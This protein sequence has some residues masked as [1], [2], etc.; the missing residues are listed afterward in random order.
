MQKLKE[1]YNLPVPI[2]KTFLKNNYLIDDKNKIK[3]FKNFLFQKEI[4]FKNNEEYIIEFTP[5]QKHEI[6]LEEYLALS[7][8]EKVQKSSKKIHYNFEKKTKNFLLGEKLYLNY[9]VNQLA[10]KQLKRQV[11]KKHFKQ[12]LLGLITD[13]PLNK[14]AHTFSITCNSFLEQTLKLSLYKYKSK[15]NVYIRRKR[16]HFFK[17]TKRSVRFLRHFKRFHFIKG[18]FE[19][20]KCIEEHKKKNEAKIRAYKKL[21]SKYRPR[22]YRRPFRLKLKPL[23]WTKWGQQQP[24][25]FSRIHFIFEIK[26][27]FRSF[28]NKK[29]KFKNKQM[30]NLFK[31]KLLKQIKQIKKK[32]L[33]LKTK[34]KEGQEE[35]RALLSKLTE[36]GVI[37]K[38]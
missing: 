19:K 26:K 36:N 16:R 14:K 5:I 23:Y 24:F 12:P 28:I 1:Q 2:Y 38:I 9:F 15:K 30:K 18:F 34:R 8:I 17:R 25:G 7:H 29:N 32:V 10:V 33:N 11:L 3:R 6:I 27:I 4:L 21:V 13:K 20:E 35:F 31:I 22:S 37:K